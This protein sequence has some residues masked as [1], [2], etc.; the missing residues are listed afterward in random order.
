MRLSIKIISLLM[1]SINTA[2]GQNHI[3]TV[4]SIPNIYEKTSILLTPD[5]I[6]ICIAKDSESNDHIYFDSCIIIKKEQLNEINLIYLKERGCDCI[7]KVMST[8]INTD[9]LLFDDLYQVK[10]WSYFIFD[11]KSYYIAQPQSV[12]GVSYN[13]SGDIILLEDYPFIR[14]L[15]ILVAFRKL[16]NT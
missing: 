11:N 5:S 4:D 15:Y 1:F 13:N 16:K 8:E 2:Y 6:P 14:N 12:H 9:S 10:I 3:F 7:Y